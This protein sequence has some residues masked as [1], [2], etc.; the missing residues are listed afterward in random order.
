MLLGTLS[1]N[2]LS[3]YILDTDDMVI[4]EYSTSDVWNNEDMQ[5]LIDNISFD[6]LRLF[7]TNRNGLIDQIPSQFKS[8]DFIYA[9]K[10]ASS[11]KAIDK[12]FIWFK[13]KKFE[14]KHEGDS[15]LL[16]DLFLDNFKAVYLEM[17]GILDGNIELH[18]YNGGFYTSYLMISPS[19]DIG[20]WVDGIDCKKEVFLR[21][22]FTGGM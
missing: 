4:E 2:R 6:K 5:N 13:G 21:E 11:M 19:R 3:C 9:V 14:F 8:D 20:L 7:D 10:Y 18:L 22:C 15:L 1:I 17:I 16:N 12:L